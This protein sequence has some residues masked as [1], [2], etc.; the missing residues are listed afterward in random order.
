MTAMTSMTNLLALYTTLAEER[1]EEPALIYQREPHVGTVLSWARLAE[2]GEELHRRL[3]D[4]GVPEAGLYAVVLA[5][6]PDMLPLLLAV[7]RLRG[8]ALLVDPEWGDRL[9]R[10]IFGH[11]EPDAFISLLPELAVS[12]AGRPGSPGAHR[13]L[14]AD[15]ALLSYTSGSTGDPKAIVMTHGRLSTTMFAAAAAVVRHRGAAPR[16]VACSMRL[17]GSGVLNLHYTWAVCADAAVVVLPQLEVRTARDYWQ[18]IERHRIDQTFLVP[19]LIELLNHLATP[20]VGDWPRPICITGSSPL[21]RRTQERFQRRFKIGLLNAFGLTESMCACFFGEYDEQGM[22]RNTIGQPALLKAR[23]RDL[24]GRLVEGPGE[25]E[26]ELCGPTLFDG[27]YR[28][29]QAT[30]AAF[31]GSWF[32]TG[33]LLRRDERGSYTTIGRS[34]DVVMKG[35]YAI[36]LNEIEEAAVD[37]DGVH[38]VAAV[39]LQ[40]PDGGEDLG[41]IVRFLAA[42]AAPDP[43]RIAAELRERLGPQRT[44]RRVVETAEALP[45]TGQE[46]LDRRRILALWQQLAG[47]APLDLRSE[48][49]RDDDRP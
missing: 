26:L 18:R 13:D 19:P 4:A 38:E 30:A 7:W 34:K 33:D 41:L 9:R 21:S 46:K 43:D 10:S 25:G 6:H 39:P 1:P 5:D 35:S 17:S 31:V 44:P 28:N 37:I 36:Y 23:L 22:G 11:S 16:R 32:R 47:H 8:A 29:A 14:P 48:M 24:S 20:P 15:A 49:L 3:L 40:L 2:R 45:R 27:Y 12:L 42:A